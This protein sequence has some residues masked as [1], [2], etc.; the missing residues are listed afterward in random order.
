MEKE[1][2]RVT[3]R[4]I[5]AALLC[6]LAIVFPVE[7]LGKL[8]LFLLPYFVIGY[9][10]VWSALRGILHGQMLDETFLMT[11]ATIGAFFLGE[12]PEAVAVMLF[13][14]L[15]ELFQD[16][17]VGKSR[18][19][20]AELMDIQPSRAVVLR[21]NKEEI[22]SPNEVLVGETILIKP[23]ERI[24]LDGKII[25]GS[26]TV[27]TAALTGESLPAE[28][29]VEER[30]A[31]GSINL[32]GVI[33]VKTES[34]YEDSTV[35]KI[36]E[37]VENAAE[38]KARSENFITRFA[39]YYTPCVVL[40][41]ILLAFLP[42]L[43]FSQMWSLWLQRA[44]IFLVVSCPC[45][46]VISVPLS[47]FGGIG[48]A[49]KM[50]ILIKGA[51]YLEQLAQVDTIAMD[52]TGTLTKGS[53]SVSEI[54]PPQDA[55]RLLKLAALAESGS[56]HPI[57]ASV[58]SAFNGI[59]DRD[60]IGDRTEY[61]GMGVS[62]NI[63][64]TLYFVGNEKLMQEANASFAETDAIGTTLHISEG[65]HYLGYLVVRDTIKPEAKE[66]IAKLHALGI[67]KTIMLTG[68]TEAVA[69]AVSKE[70]GVRTVY[71]SLLPSEK[72]AQVEALIDNGCKLA[73]VG[74]GINDAPVLTRADIGIAMGALGSDA[75][76]EAADVVLMDDNLAKLPLAIRIARKTMGIVQQNIVFALGV[77]AIL[78]VL[79]ALGMANL[80]MAVFGDVGVSI[81]AVLNA[82]RAMMEIS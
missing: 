42:P 73:F 33:Q 74:D 21:S 62:A 26:T 6:L 1:Q 68:D 61:P 37:L 78:L 17:A 50:G 19:S 27:D 11:L 38:K 44:L 80:W 54:H 82:M 81:L 65:S 67:E 4:L 13:Y 53:F 10:V 22:V 40:G 52:K 24:P 23:G 70:A 14:Q 58:V 5:A 56:T 45:A 20:I 36:L 47:F 32:S 48:G 72:V 60:R 71:A 15:G 59:L 25:Q 29:T 31:S 16:I 2:K 41:A 30:V 51:N 18:K 3:V 46:L 9:D 63:D 66:S 39:R 49:S 43:L 55:E 76:I 79:G 64:G 12:Y 28:K 34:L 77:K 75:A 8:V 7:G 69:N 35:A 57:A